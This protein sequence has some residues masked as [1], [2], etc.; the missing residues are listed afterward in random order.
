MFVPIVGLVGSLLPAREG[1]LF[2][3]TPEVPFSGW[4]KVKARLDDVMAVAP[5]K[6]EPWVIH[7]LRHTISTHLNEEPDA[8]PDLIDRL[9]AHKRRGT[10]A[11]YNHARLV[12][13][14]KR[15]L[16]QWQKVLRRGGVL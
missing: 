8:N 11:L 10:E 5:G 9:L 16:L 2:G 13:G 3:R 15:L 6:V 1:F 4:S 14:R 7:D 12:E